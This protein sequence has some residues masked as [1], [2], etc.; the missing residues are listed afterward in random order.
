LI[1]PLN[2]LQRVVF[3]ESQRPDLLEDAGFG[4]LLKAPVRRA[5]G[6]NAGGAEGIPLAA[7]AQGEEDGIHG[8]AVIDARPL[9][10][11]RMRWP[12]G[13]ERLNPLPRASGMLQ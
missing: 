8:A 13:Q 3:L 7:G 6:T 10:A 9:A 2:L 1:G 12:R 11:Q 4:P 5:A